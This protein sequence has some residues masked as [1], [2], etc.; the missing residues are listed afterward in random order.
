VIVRVTR[1]TVTVVP[2]QLVGLPPGGVTSVA[3]TSVSISVVE[4]GV[5]DVA[6]A[7]VVEGFAV[8]AVGFGEGGVPPVTESQLLRPTENGAG[9]PP[10]GSTVLPSASTTYHAK[11]LSVCT[12]SSVGILAVRRERAY[13]IKLVDDGRPRLSAGDLHAVP[14]ASG[15]HVEDVI[16]GNNVV[17]LWLGSQWAEEPV[18]ADEAA[19]SIVRGNSR[20]DALLELL[21]RGTRRNR[22]DLAC[23]HLAIRLTTRAG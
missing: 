3:S 17:G 7:A 1:A 13:R 21:Q 8:V 18:P 20:Q 2:E 15:V 23:V 11:D 4:V 19:V 16:D 14:P 6:G 9:E 5:A 10:A 12:R 22:M